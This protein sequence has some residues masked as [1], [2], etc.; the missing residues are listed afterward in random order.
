MNQAEENKEIKQTKTFFKLQC[1]S[2]KKN[3]PHIKFHHYPPPILVGLHTL[4]LGILELFN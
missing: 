1:P 2:N 3:Y 4:V